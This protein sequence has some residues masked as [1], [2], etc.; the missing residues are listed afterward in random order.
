MVFFTILPPGNENLFE[1]RILKAFTGLF[2]HNP[3]PQSQTQRKWLVG[4]SRGVTIKPRGAAQQKGQVATGTLK[5]SYKILFFYMKT[6][7]HRR[8]TT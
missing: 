8:Q 7:N 4:H 1:E 3:W 2:V 6:T 5:R